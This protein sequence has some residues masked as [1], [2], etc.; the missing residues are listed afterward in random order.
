[1]NKYRQVLYK[2]HLSEMYVPYMDPSEDWYFIT[3]LDC[4]EFGCGQSAVSLEPYT[5]CPAG[6]VFF[7]GIFAGQDGTPTN[8]SKAMCIFEKNA[9]DIMWRHTEAEVPGLEVIINISFYDIYI[10]II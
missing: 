10:F 6:A 4:G 9:G 1:M 5:D 3:Y 8:I 2:G 7:D